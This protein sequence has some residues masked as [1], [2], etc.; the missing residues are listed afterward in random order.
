MTIGR[1]RISRNYIFFQCFYT[2]CLAVFCFLSVTLQQ[3]GK[4]MR[5]RHIIATGIILAL[6][7]GASI[8]IA[9]AFSHHGRVETKHPDAQSMGKAIT[10]IL[11]GSQRKK[12]AKASDKKPAA[13][14]KKTDYAISGI[15][16]DTTGMPM[17]EVVISDGFTCAK[18]DSAGRYKMTR[19]PQARFVFYTVPDYCEVPTHSETDRTACFYLPISAG[20]KTYDFTLVRLPNGK[21]EEYKMIVIGDPQVTNTVNPHYTG[22]DDNPVRKSDVERFT[23]QT[24]ADIRQ[25]IRKLPK[26]TPVYGLSMG[27]DVQYYGG[28]NADLERQIRESLGES[29]MRLF[30]V[31]GN[32][33]TDGKALY[34][35]KWEDN[36]GPTNYS[37]DRG[38]EH[39]VCI[40]NV[41]FTRKKGYY[42]PGELT[43]A[44]MRWL[45]QDLALA[46]KD[47]KVILCYHIPF[48]FGTSPYSKARSLGIQSEEGHYSSSRLSA[49]LPLLEAFRGGYELFCGH[50]H[51]AINH[52]IEYA[53]RHVMEHCHAASCG[54]IWQSNINICGTPNG[55]YVYTFTGPRLSNC[56]YKG[57]FWDASKQMALFR[58]DTDFNGESYAADWNLPR[59][60]NVLVANVF[61]ADSRWRVVAVEEGKEYPM[62]R[63]SGKGQDAFATGYHHKYAQ[64]T[65]YH[66]VSKSNGY[67]IMNHLFHYVPKNPQ[68][69]ITVR[70]TD[71][72][73]NVYTANSSEVITDPFMNYAHYYQNGR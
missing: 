73:G 24:M 18:T 36:W 33:D 60:Q 52:E 53:G 30:S 51:F 47:K 7:I 26:G 8:G 42:S 61:N 70:A 66:F 21:E 46:S 37:F 34:R 12:N 44:Q 29:E 64:A 56:Y 2:A 31:I 10:Q 54:N 17:P 41:L 65:P 13:T 62:L 6:C 5:R 55:Y 9:M 57:T 16:R 22:P 43:E 71:P 58:A 40:D 14:S 1:I 39:Y 32:H 25:T 63:I 19:N 23:S 59:G 68:A 67:L 50:T 45:R 48:T 28:Y 72:Y 35:Q 38:D 4:Q 69:P 3:K 15:V 11:A 27:D 49:L 20:R